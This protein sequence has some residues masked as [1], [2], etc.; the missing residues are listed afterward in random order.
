ML[1]VYMQNYKQMVPIQRKHASTNITVF[2]VNNT[3]I[4]KQFKT[5]IGMLEFE[6]AS[7][8]QQKLVESHPQ[9]SEAEIFRGFV[10]FLATK[11]DHQVFNVPLGKLQAIPQERMKLFLILSVEENCPV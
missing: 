10:R 4:R 8:A 11:V 1:L 3:A 6:E 2:S 9:M 7:E 5:N